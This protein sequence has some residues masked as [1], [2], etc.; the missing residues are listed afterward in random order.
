MNNSIVDYLNSKG[1][2]SDYQ[3]RAS[4]ASANGIQNYSG[5]AEQNLQLL[6]TLKSQGTTPS[7][8]M[9]AIGVSEMNTKNGTMNLPQPSP[10]NP[11][12]DV[13][14]IKS[15]SEYIA[16]SFKSADKQ[17]QDM[18]AKQKADVNSIS[19]TMNKLLNKTADTQLAEKTA[20]VDVATQEYNKYLQDLADINAQSSSLS[21][22]AQAIPLQLQEQVAGQGVTDAGL[23]PT[24]AGEL[25]KNAIKQLALA[26]RADI[27]T[28]SATGSL[29]KLT[30]AK[31]RAQQIVDLTYKP[32]EDQLAIKMKQYELNK[33]ILSGID[34]KR[35]E[36]L[37][38]TLQL[39]QTALAN[40][41]ADEKIKADLITKAALNAPQ[42]LLEKAKN[43]PDST[44]AAIIL[45][46]YA[47]DFLQ[48]EKLKQEV[49][50]LQIENGTYNPISDSGSIGIVSKDNGFGLEDFKRGIS[51]V[52]SAGSGGYSALGKIIESG[53]LK[54]DRA[55]G[56]Y[57]VMG[58]NIP[59]W[60]KQALGYSM[61]PQQFLAS[62]QAQEKVFED[63][64]ER[65]YAK[66]GNWGDVAS[67]WFSDRPLSGNNSSDGNNT[68]PEYVQKV[69]KNMGVTS[70][71]APVEIQGVSPQIM[72]NLNAGKILYGQVVEPSTGLA[73]KKLSSATID[74]YG[75]L[76]DLINKTKEYETLFEEVQ[77]EGLTGVFGTGVVKGTK[78]Y[79]A[80]SEKAT[81]LESLRQEFVD[82]IARFR[83]GAALTKEE[84]KTYKERLPSLFSSDTFGNPDVQ[85]A[86]MIDNLSNTLESKMSANG[87][88]FAPTE[89]DVYYAR[90]NGALSGLSTPSSSG[91]DANVY[92]GYKY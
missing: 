9:G 52:E 42:D 79:I 26:Q 60:T 5:T 45:G 55:Y 75:T 90:M 65:N 80:P 2:A 15:T 53:S 92:Y 14:S 11:A 32:L 31:E 13:S 66:Y 61:T 10:Y 30:L 87:V 44:S 40:K 4:L 88:V 91:G 12:P 28:A 85:I 57:Q 83:T 1:Q 6:N 48:Q 7:Q 29:N 89:L 62:P 56:K 74:D 19:E 67:V 23:A 18:L 38:V 8:S 34:K 33:D 76:R 24:Q 47:Q 72:N 3:S 17:Y 37:G 43:A 39:E 49:I 86:S 41:K 78:N 22:E 46:K 70:K 81:K 21:R 71:P 36:A 63:Q 54:G 68:V 59:S 82:L 69:F 16:D 35:T 64:S 84:Q 20:G 58:S 50:K 27:A 77:N 51:A 73:P 25:R